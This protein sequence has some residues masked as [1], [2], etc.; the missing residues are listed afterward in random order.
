MVVNP[1]YLQDIPEQ[2]GIIFCISYVSN[3]KNSVGTN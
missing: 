3:T 2:V 1:E